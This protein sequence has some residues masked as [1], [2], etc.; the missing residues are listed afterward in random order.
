MILGDI[1]LG[2]P[3]VQRVD[4]GQS[5]QLATTPV[6]PTPKSRDNQEQNQHQAPTVL[7]GKGDKESDIAKDHQRRQSVDTGIF[8]KLNQ[9]YKVVLGIAQA[10]PGK[11]NKKNERT[12]SRATQSI[13]PSTSS[14]QPLLCGP[15]W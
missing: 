4:R 14:A 3:N 13:G 11:P 6:S 5:S 1:P 9:V 8:N 7:T 12:H 10:D 15:L 2:D